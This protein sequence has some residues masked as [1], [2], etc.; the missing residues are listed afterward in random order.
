MQ[1]SQQTQIKFLVI[2]NSFFWEWFAHY[3][4]T[5]PSV[6]SQNQKE[7][8]RKTGVVLMRTQQKKFINRP[9]T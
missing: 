9:N 2:V 5:P 8:T 7:N 1:L 6:W 3:I 4:Q